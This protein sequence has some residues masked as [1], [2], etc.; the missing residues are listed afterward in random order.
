M[1]KYIKQFVAT[2]LLPLSLGVAGCADNDALTGNP[3]LTLSDY[4][5]DVPAE[6]ASVDEY[7]FVLMNNITAQTASL[8]TYDVRSNQEWYLDIEWEAGTEQGWLMP[9]PLEGE[10]DGKIRFCAKANDGLESRSVMATLRYA[11]GRASDVSFYI[12]QN[13]NQPYLDVTINSK[14][15][16]RVASG[17]AQNSVD[18]LVKSN[19]YYLCSY[20]GGDWFRTSQEGNIVSVLFDE[21]PQDIEMRQGELVFKGIGAHSHMQSTLKVVQSAQSFSD[22]SHITIE[23]LLASIPTTGGVVDENLYIEGYVVSDRAGK[24]IAANQLVIQDNSRRGLIIDFDDATENTFTTG[25]KMKVW[26]LDKYIQN[27]YLHEFTVNENVF[28]EESDATGYESV[29]RELNTLE[30]K[31]NLVGTWVRITNAEWAFPYSTYYPGDEANAY[32]ATAAGNST[33]KA[34]LLRSSGGGHVRAYLYGG[35]SESDGALFKH[36]RLLPKGNGALKGILMSRHHDVDLSQNITILRMTNGN[37]DEI[38]AV[39]SRGYNDIVEF[40]FDAIDDGIHDITPRKGEGKLYSTT[41]TQWMIPEVVGN[42]YKGYCYWRMDLSQ[43]MSA[44]N[45]HTGLNVKQWNGINANSLFKTIG[46][47]ANGDAS[48]G[49][50][51]IVEF[52]TAGVSANEE[53]SIAIATSSSSTGPRDFVV[54]WGESMTGTFTAVDSYQATNWDAYYC[55]T[56]SMFTLPAACNGKE[57]VVVRLRVSSGRRANINSTSS[58]GDSGTNRMCGV[59]VSKRNK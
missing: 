25:T 27:G 8:I 1:I 36:E 38:P 47:P 51:W 12:K 56:E 24:N 34:R 42:F 59:V 57:N 5:I 19:I 14:T 4:K 54:E 50:A 16:T 21:L 37:D 44:T 49:E 32:N 9:Y 15:A 23:Q 13:S 3:Y 22:A 6:V 45:T 53:V 55:P 26:M 18:L 35:T 41:S 46:Y 31:E 58:I 10:G 48:T 29:I 20:A 30:G 39:G 2:A 33:D 43:P 52:S 40:V 28:D 7:G 17:R 11:D